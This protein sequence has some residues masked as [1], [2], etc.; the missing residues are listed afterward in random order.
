MSDLHFQSSLSEGE[1]Q[2]SNE[3]RQQLT[4]GEFWLYQSPFTIIYLAGMSYTIEDMPHTFARMEEEDS[5]VTFDAQSIS[6][7]SAGTSYDFAL[8]SV[9]H[10]GKR[11]GISETQRVSFDDNG[12]IEPIG[13]HSTLTGI[14]VKE[15][16]FKLSIRYNQ[17]NQPATP[18]GFKIY[19]DSSSLNHIGTIN[20][21]SGRSVYTFTTPAYSHGSSREFLVRTFRTVE[22]TDKEHK[23]LDAITLVAD[24]TGPTAVTV[25][26]TTY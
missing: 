18:N 15:G 14:A 9:G 21:V 23:N 6:M 7:V 16:K 17:T 24:T 10:S 5:T 3:W 19:E 1:Y 22:G 4:E 13:N 2:P 20:F 11:G 8:A 26:R 25:I 12:L